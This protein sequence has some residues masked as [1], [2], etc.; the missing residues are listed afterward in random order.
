VFEDDALLVVDKPSG[1]LTVA[2]EGEKTD[3]L[4]VRLNDYLR[5]RT[6]SRR[7]RAWVVHRL[8]RETSGLMIFAKSDAVKDLLKANWQNVEKTYLAV[9]RG[10]PTIEQ[11]T[12]AN[13]LVED[14]AS[15][16]VFAT[17][18]AGP[19]ARRA[20]SHYR[21][22]ESNGGRSIVE[23]KLVTG[24][25]HQIRVHLAGLGCPVLGDRRYAEKSHQVGSE[26]GRLALHATRLRFAHPT[27]GEALAFESTL[28]NALRQLLR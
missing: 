6:S 4:F 9:V 20:I 18:R 2:T 21:V 11:G 8:D 25:K 7:E 23:V 12:V 14:D 19:K 26:R 15:L 16:K 10:K 17:D 27:T 28:P 5:G 1:L 22:L 3:T 13:Y 24:Q